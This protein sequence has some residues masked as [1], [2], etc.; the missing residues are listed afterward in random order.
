MDMDDF[1]FGLPE[2][3]FVG[4]ELETPPTRSIDT[5]HP[6]DSIHH[7]ASTIPTV[8]GIPILGIAGDGDDTDNDTDNNYTEEESKD[9]DLD[10]M[11]GIGIDEEEI[12]GN[13]IDAWD[14]EPPLSTNSPIIESVYVPLTLED[15]ERKSYDLYCWV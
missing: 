1:D 9:D 3:P 12:Q 8:F 4:Q 11:S 6:V 5:T 2:A 14:L 15:H 13:Y 10:D 7:A